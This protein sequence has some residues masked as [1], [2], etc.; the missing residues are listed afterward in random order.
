MGLA[1]RQSQVQR[2]TGA[3]FRVVSEEQSYLAAD[4]GIRQKPG[5]L[6]SMRCWATRIDVDG[7]DELR[8]AE[9]P[10]MSAEEHLA[11]GHALVFSVPVPTVAISHWDS[12]ARVAGECGTPGGWCLLGTRES[13]RC[14]LA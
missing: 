13:E 1:Q 14:E 6:A 4:L 7:Y 3:E 11:V 8:R 12:W 2:A 5:G 9:V 10:Q